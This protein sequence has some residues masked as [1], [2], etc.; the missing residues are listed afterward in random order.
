MWVS[1]VKEV[2]NNKS[3]PCFLYFGCLYDVE[4]HNGTGVVVINGDVVGD[5]VGDDGDFEVDG[6][7]AVLSSANGGEMCDTLTNAVKLSG[8]AS[9]IF[10]SFNFNVSFTDSYIV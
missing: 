6:E 9:V 5:V 1:T 10:F 4:D 3:I 7:G 2:K 8:V